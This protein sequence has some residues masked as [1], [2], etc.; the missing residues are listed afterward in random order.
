MG[1]VRPWELRATESPLPLTHQEIE[2][3]F[4][5]DSDEV[6]ALAADGTLI[7]DDN[8]LLAYGLDRFTRADDEGWQWIEHANARNH[9]IVRHYRQDASRAR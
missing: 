2:D 7:T 5:L 4:V 3:A 9:W 8:Q 6:A 1:S